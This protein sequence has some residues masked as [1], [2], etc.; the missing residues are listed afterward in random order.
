MTELH[1]TEQISY[2]LR[3]L[4]A[5]AKTE[6]EAQELELMLEAEKE[7][8]IRDYIRANLNDLASPIKFQKLQEAL[9]KGEIAYSGELTRNKVIEWSK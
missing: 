5:E 1:L 7:R 3:S 9:E 6:R 4:E 2:Q 8:E